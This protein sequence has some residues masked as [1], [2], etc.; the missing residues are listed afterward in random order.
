[1]KAPRVRCFSLLLQLEHF[2]LGCTP[3]M[4]WAESLHQREIGTRVQFSNIDTK[5][6]S[7]DNSTNESK[8][9]DIQAQNIIRGEPYRLYH[10][11]FDL[12]VLRF[13]SNLLSF[14]SSL[15]FLSS[16]IYYI[17]IVRST[18]Y[19]AVAI[20]AIRSEKSSYC[21]DICLR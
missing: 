21:L 6:R 1:M 15:C 10:W 12:P 11:T 7:K 2:S 16:L 4:T 19:F 20:G 5:I 8:K 18:D 9:N 3:K 17:F 14:L 13:L